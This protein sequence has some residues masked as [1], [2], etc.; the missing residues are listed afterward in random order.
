MCIKKLT[1]LENV[2]ISDDLVKN[3]NMF[4]SHVFKSE[5]LK[6]YVK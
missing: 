2:R 3:E 1:F 6:S 4:I 5:Y